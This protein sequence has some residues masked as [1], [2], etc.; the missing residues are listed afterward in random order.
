MP[1][2][3]RPRIFVKNCT[4]IGNGGAAIKSEAPMVVENCLFLKNGNYP[5]LRW[6]HLAARFKRWRATN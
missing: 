6:W 4:F 2:S 1:D 3:E 5:E